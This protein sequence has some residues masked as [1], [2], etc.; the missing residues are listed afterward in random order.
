MTQ[1]IIIAIAVALKGPICGLK[2]PIILAFALVIPSVSRSWFVVVARLI[3]VEKFIILLK[4]AARVLV[5]ATGLES[6][7][8]FL[9]RAL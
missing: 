1:A 7:V 3:R 2:M 4:K 8:V 5:T 6:L 9:S